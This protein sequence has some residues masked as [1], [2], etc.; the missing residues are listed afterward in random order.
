[1]TPEQLTKLVKDL[2]ALPRETE[3]V[4]FKENNDNPEEIGEYLSAIANSAALLQRE[5]GYIVWGVRDTDHK[6][7]GTTFKPRVA[8]VKMQELEN[9]LTVLLQPEIHFAIDE[10]SVDGVPVVVFEVPAAAHTPVRFKDFEFIR[11]GSYKKKLRDHPEKERRLWSILSSGSFEA[12]VAHAG[13]GPAEVVALLDHSAFFKLLGQQVPPNIDAVVRRFAD[14]DIIAARSDGQF[15]IRNLGAILFARDLSAFAR[16]RRKAVRVV[17]YEGSGRTKAIREREEQSGYGNAFQSLLDYID[18][19]L[20]V[21]ERIEHGLRVNQRAYP[22]DTIREPLANALIHQDFSITGAGPL[23]EIF[24]DRIEI[25]NPG[26]P[27]VSPERFLDAPSRSRNEALAALMRRMRICEERGTGID[28]VVQAAEDSLLPAPDFQVVNDQTRVVIN[29]PRS[30][31]D[32]TKEERLRATYQH[33]CL[34][35]V[36]NQRMTNASLRKRFG[37]AEQ[38]LAMVSR[39][40][41]EAVEAGLIKPF[42][43]TSKSRRLSQYV[44]YWTT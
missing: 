29:A 42:D 33:A 8:K 12:E 26:T 37:I 36:S 20:P 35:W 5:R 25:T 7:V 32:M 40:I 34:Q 6:I 19:Q 2:A 39:V 30:F 43:P 1:M 4:E 3:W 41:A 38:N 15:D 24:S 10:G 23:V 11:V 17:T 14:E 18:S 22:A 28:K 9:W 44:P 16:L 13:V 27:L 31:T 21:R